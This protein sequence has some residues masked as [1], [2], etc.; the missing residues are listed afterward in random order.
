MQ[1]LNEKSKNNCDIFE[2]IKCIVCKNSD[3][4]LFSIKYRKQNC[5]IVKCE[6]CSFHFIPPYYRKSVDYTEY[7]SQDVV[8]QV[9]DA[10]VWIKIQ[11]NLLR[12]QLIH[13]YKKDK[14]HL[15]QPVLQYQVQPDL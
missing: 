2:N 7:K 13:R 12:Y 8:N 1:K 5:S 14:Q 9:K 11:R 3:K 6:V 4:E 10:N 15:R